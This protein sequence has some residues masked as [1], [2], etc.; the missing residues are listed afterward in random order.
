M[1]ELLRCFL[2][3]YRTKAL[4]GIST[5]V[6]EVVLEILTPLVVARMIDVGVCAKDVGEVLRMG[7]VLVAFALV[8]YAFTLI[9]QRLAAQVSQG[10]GT[11]VRNALYRHI[12]HLSMSQVNRFGTPSLVTRITNDV[13]QVQLAVALGIRTLTRWPLLALGSLVAALLIDMR[14]GLVFLVCLPLIT[15]VFALVMRSSIPYYRTMQKR[16][17]TISLVTRESLSGM[18]VIRA[19]GQESREM[20]RGE[21]A[22]HEQVETA[23]GVGRLS[24]LL[25]P[26]TF[27]VMN[28]GVATILWVGGIEVNVGDLTT[29]EVMAFVNYMTQ[30]LVSISYLANLVVVLMRGQTSAARI[31]QVLDCAPDLREGTVAD[32]PMSQSKQE[33]VPALAFDGVS[34]AYDQAGASALQEVRFSLMPG[35]TLGIIGG[36]GSGK[37]TL[38]GLAIRLYD[39]TQGSVSVF[40]RD[41]REYTFERLRSLVSV[42]PQ[43]V[44][45]VSGTIR[46]NLCWRHPQASD[47]ELWDALEA[48]QAADFVRALP[49]GLDAEVE[50]GGRNFS[51]GQR[52]RLSIARALVGRPRLLLLDDAASALDYATDARLRRALR[53][54]HDQTSTV[55]VSQRV[56]AIRSSER[57]I[58]LDHGRMVGTGTHEELLHG[59][60]IYQEICASQMRQG[61][62]E[63]SHG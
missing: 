56:S 18:R 33:A 15:A 40:G 45:L 4:I 31:M 16:L 42:V 27:L 36:T 22:I 13:N 46:T 29:G 41:V 7:A 62:G 44:S 30:T 34:Y 9:C 49:E 12:N 35:Q 37:S 17:D 59:C 47:D 61:E 53:A 5:K 24:S 32:D 3:P 50:A 23:I 19:F 10:M 63:V 20:A 51:G 58:V 28:L 43:Q 11:E 25:N 2:R 48:A 21:H 14:L 39:P 6:V 1:L 26:A 55:I 8:S 57:I 54:L 60:A 38:V 52:Q